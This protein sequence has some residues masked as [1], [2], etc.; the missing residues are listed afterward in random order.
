MKLII[1]IDEVGRGCWA[2]PLV[3]GAVLLGRPI[4][5]LSDS[6]KLSRSARER[7]DILIRQQAIACGLG[8]VPAK[9]IDSGGISA[10]VKTA[11]QQAI[12][13]LLAVY[14]GPI[15]EVIIDGT[16]NY[17]AERP[18]TRALVKADDHVPAVSAASIL[19]KVARDRY[20]ASLSGDL[21]VYSFDKH[22]G[23]GTALHLSRLQQFGVSPQHRR[24]FKPVQQIE[25]A[26]R[27]RL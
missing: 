7:L 17:L 1:G 22:V 20:M 12:A 10:A 11:M 4:E 14:S 2:G 15:D 21:S 27:G 9:A 19:A 23:Y 5:G 25:L 6:K 3:A 16:I 24:S 26:G 13:E 8:W 18:D